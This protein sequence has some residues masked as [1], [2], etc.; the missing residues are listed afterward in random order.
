MTE[1]W[2]PVV[3]YEELYEVS[4]HGR[5]RSLDRWVT[6]GRGMR[7]VAGQEMS[8]LALNHGHLVAQLSRDGVNSKILV[9]RLVL[10][11]FVGP[12]PDGQHGL[13]YNDV[14]T[15]NRLENLRWG[16]VSE[17]RY[18]CV[19]NGNH[20]N[21]RKN[22]CP[23]GHSLVP[24]PYAPGTRFCRVCRNEANRRYRQ[25]QKVRA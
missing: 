10:E 14:P 22:E 4:D 6:N 2:L 19:R 3:G 16:T 21:A 9:H 8:L 25:R 23:Q 5:V 20:V 7:L 1:R 17:N 15:D 12:C 13:H 24:N 11:A 18:D